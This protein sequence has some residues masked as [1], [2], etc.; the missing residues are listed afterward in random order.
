MAISQQTPKIYIQIHTSYIQQD[1]CFTR[2]LNDCLPNNRLTDFTINFNSTNNFHKRNIK[3]QTNPKHVKI[4]VSELIVAQF[5]KGIAYISKLYKLF[6]AK[7]P[8][9]KIK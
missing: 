8:Q 9:F 5:L 3:F 7:F 2:L 4:H 1:Q 6:T